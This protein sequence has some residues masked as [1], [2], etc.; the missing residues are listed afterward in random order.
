ML[1]D[2]FKA[3]CAGRTDNVPRAE[4]YPLMLWASGSVKAVKAAQFVNAR[5]MFASPD[6]MLGM[7]SLALRGERF[8]RYPKTAA[9][10]DDKIEAFRTLAMKRYGWSSREFE[11]NANVQRFIDAEELAA[12]SGATNKERKVLGLEPLVVLKVKGKGAGMAQTAINIAQ[13][14]GKW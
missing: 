2:S 9:K 5:M 12:W 1:L 14:W 13:A 6:L 8:V 10:D 4:L 3:L 7:L 11:A